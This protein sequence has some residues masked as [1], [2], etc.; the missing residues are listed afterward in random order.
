MWANTEKNSPQTAGNPAVELDLS[1]Y[2]AAPTAAP[3]SQAGCFPICRNPEKTLSS[4]AVKDELQA[5]LHVEGLTGVAMDVRV[6]VYLEDF[7]KRTDNDLGTW[8]ALRL[9]EGVPLD[10][11]TTADA[12]TI[13][14]IPIPAMATHAYLQRA[15]VTGAPTATEGAIYGTE[16]TA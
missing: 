1:S 6:W 16:E 12:G 10:A 7:K 2:T 13:Y 15:A 5:V 11:E 8:K 3:T 4:R 14:R 9:L